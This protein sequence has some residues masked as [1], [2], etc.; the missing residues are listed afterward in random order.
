MTQS[1]TKTKPNHFNVDSPLVKAIK[2]TIVIAA[3]GVVL[4]FVFLAT[5]H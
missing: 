2:F 1:R 4:C 3:I 5:E